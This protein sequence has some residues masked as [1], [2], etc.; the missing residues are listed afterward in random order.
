MTKQ[1]LRKLLK[2]A[3]HEG[4]LWG[5]IYS[6]SFIPTNKQHK[7]KANETVSKIF[8]QL[9]IEQNSDRQS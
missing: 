3:F 8:K 2:Q 7:N 9:E 6:S 4:R 1:K 5:E